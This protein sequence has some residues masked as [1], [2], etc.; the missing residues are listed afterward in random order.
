MSAPPPLADLLALLLPV[1][2][3][4]LLL[5]TCLRRGAAARRAW[6]GWLGVVEHPRRH[7]V[8]SATGTKRLLP[9]LHHALRENGIDPGRELTPYLRTV[10]LRERHRAGHLA[11]VL[12]QAADALAARG[13]EPILLKGAAL[14]HTVYPDPALRHCHDLDLLIEPGDLAAAGDA[15]AAAGFAVTA[16]GPGEALALH[17]GTV[18][19]A[20]HAAPL[21]LPLFRL[22]QADLRA[23]S[24]P[25]PIAG[26]TLRILDP[27]DM[28]LQLCG[29]ALCQGGRDRV[30]WVADAALL[31]RRE[32]AALDWD[33]LAAAATASG[34]ALPLATMLA[35]LPG[36]ADA[37]PPADA[38]AAL[39]GAARASPAAARDATLA[40]LRRG[41]RAGADTLLAAGGWRSRAALARFLLL[42]SPAYLAWWCAETGRR[43]WPL[44]YLGRPLGLARRGG[45]RLAR[46]R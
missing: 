36:L 42:P 17:P 5:G 15:L 4:A 19:V 28:L 27:A 33:R 38:L 31:L 43:G 35:A 20:L 2:G 1:Q 24:R 10:A 25:R 3:E 32:G 23:R 12:R 34:L 30:S 7:L 44:W 16:T 46:R 11:A 21:P 41:P 18:P 8:I 22:P 26:A 14:A 13:L 40:A 29:L 6:E 45:R 37:A 39:A 9:L